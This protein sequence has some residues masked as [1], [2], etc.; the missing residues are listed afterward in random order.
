MQKTWFFYDRYNIIFLA[1]PAVLSTA[2][3]AR[4]SSA[5]RLQTY[6]A[7]DEIS[8]GVKYFPSFISSFYNLNESELNFYCFRNSPFLASTS[9]IGNI[10]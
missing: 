10:A 3:I 7:E 9:F 6:K 2:V 4:S 5:P 1:G 8:V